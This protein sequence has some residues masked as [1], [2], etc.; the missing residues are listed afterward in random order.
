M[1]PFKQKEAEEVT[2]LRTILAGCAESPQISAI[3]VRFWK[4][5]IETPRHLPC[6]TWRLGTKVVTFKCSPGQTCWDIPSLLFCAE[7]RYRRFPSEDV[8]GAV[9]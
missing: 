7:V 3:Q 5:S 4:C 2:K 1:E 6:A 8:T 9:R